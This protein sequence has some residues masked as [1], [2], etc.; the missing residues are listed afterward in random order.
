VA[1]YR[2]TSKWTTAGQ[3]EIWLAR[4]QESGEEVVMKRL[5]P[6]RQLS[7]PA[8][9]LR[10]FHREVRSQGA[11]EHPGIMPIISW[12]FSADPPWYTMP[13]AQRNLGDYIDGNPHGLPEQEVIDI[14]LQVAEAV[15]HA[16]QEGIYHRDIKPGNI[17]KL[18]GR[19][20][21]ADSDSAGTPIRTA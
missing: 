20:V 8:A 14:M 16:H 18:K 3:A 2:R 5:L 7:D 6:D 21:V 9:E 4:D 11:L 12:N 17:L 10:R 19:W 1:R 15:S 13:R